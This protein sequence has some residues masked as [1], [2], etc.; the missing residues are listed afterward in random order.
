MRFDAQ[1]VIPLAEIKLIETSEPLILVGSDLMAPPAVQKGWRFWDIGYD[2]NDIGTIRFRKQKHTRP[3]QLLAWPTVRPEMS[4][5]R[6][7]VAPPQAAAPAKPSTKPPKPPT[8]T[9][10]SSIKP[11]A[12]KATTKPS[13]VAATPESR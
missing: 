5:P 3:V 2:D 12:Q 8:L 11:A 7:Y 4:A 1:V 13:T 10:A 6:P 9:R